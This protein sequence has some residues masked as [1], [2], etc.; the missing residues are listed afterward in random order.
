[1]EVVPEVVSG[2]YSVL[3]PLYS[4][5]LVPLCI[6]REEQ[7][8]SAVLSDCQL[9]RSC[10]KQ[11][12]SYGFPYDETVGWKLQSIPLVIVPASFDTGAEQAD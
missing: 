8:Q 7:S 6:T 1:M 9:T 11:M 5:K 2:K 10:A 12:S 3:D 4:I